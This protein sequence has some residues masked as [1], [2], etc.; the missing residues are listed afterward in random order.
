MCIQNWQNKPKLSNLTWHSLCKKMQNSRLQL[1]CF[2]SLELPGIL[3]SFWTIGGD[4][5][6]QIR[7]ISHRSDHTEAYWNLVWHQPIT[8]NQNTTRCYI[9]CTGVPNWGS[10]RGWGVSGKRGR[11]VVGSVMCSPGE[12]QVCGR[13]ASFRDWVWQKRLFHSSE[14]QVWRIVL[15]P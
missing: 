15:K 9:I 13:K 7:P 1:A 3:H 2:I 14:P 10:T 4:V 12:F 8:C 6:D 11:V 5:L